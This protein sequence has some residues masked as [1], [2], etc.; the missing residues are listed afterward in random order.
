MAHPWKGVA[1]A[2]TLLLIVAIILLIMSTCC[3]PCSPNI[4][5]KECII[6]NAISHTTESIENIHRRSMIPIQM[7]IVTIETR[8]SLNELVALHNANM[9]KYCA[10]HDYHYV[11]MNSYASDRPIYWQK[12]ELVLYTMLNTD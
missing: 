4:P 11:F 7:T 5:D 8:S 12:L 1:I 6:Q 3:R 2:M 9:T 10:I